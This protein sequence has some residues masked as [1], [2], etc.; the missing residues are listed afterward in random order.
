MILAVLA[1]VS[2]FVARAIWG[3]LGGEP[4]YARQIARSIVVARKS[5]DS[6]SLLAMLDDMKDQLRKMVAGILESAEAIGVATREIS[7]GNADL[8]SR[9]EEQERSLSET[10][11][12]LA[13]LAGTVANNADT[14]RQANDLVISA[15]QI[16]EKGGDVVANV[17][18]TM[19]DIH[20]SARRINDITRL[21]DS[22]AFQT[23]ILTLNAAVE[24]VRARVS[25]DGDL[26]W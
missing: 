6:T 10:A 22:I 1:A 25:G 16:A 24:A 23:N 17:V 26:Q 19:S 20:E 13:E 3:D 11:S 4:S 15:A 5:G 9:T 2:H 8:F 12:S 21:I 7:S 18:M 14:A